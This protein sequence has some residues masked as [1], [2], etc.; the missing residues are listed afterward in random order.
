MT[1]GCS[2]GKASEIEFLSSALPA[3]PIR[4]IAKAGFPGQLR[5]PLVPLRKL[6]STFKEVG[7]GDRGGGGGA[8]GR[9]R[10]LH[11]TEGGHESSRHWDATTAG[12]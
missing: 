1:V 5:V 7:G 11:G 8:A 12:A 4:L 6:R 3:P 9:T 10:H 2:V